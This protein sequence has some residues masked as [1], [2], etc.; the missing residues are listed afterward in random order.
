M[1]DA[2]YEWKWLS[3]WT[4]IWLATKTNKCWNIH[5]IIE[6][7]HLSLFWISKKKDAVGDNSLDGDL[8]HGMDST[9]HDMFAWLITANKLTT[10]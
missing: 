6:K 3:I 10:L 5:N 7:R 1:L 9:H 8:L 2:E 4:K